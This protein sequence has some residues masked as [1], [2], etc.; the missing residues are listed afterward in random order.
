MHVTVLRPRRERDAVARGI[1]IVPADHVGADD[2]LQ[3]DAHALVD[4]G[5]PTV[6]A[7]IPVA[8]SDALP[9]RSGRR[10]ATWLLRALVLPPT[11]HPC[12]VNAG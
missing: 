7:V 6:A 2:R 1:R 11:D 10:L 5:K 4:H 3:R 8:P 12:P 9:D